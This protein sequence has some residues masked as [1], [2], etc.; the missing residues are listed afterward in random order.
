[1]SDFV[2]NSKDLFF[3]S[4]LISYG[5]DCLLSDAL[6]IISALS[7]NAGMSIIRFHSDLGIF[8]KPSLPVD[9]W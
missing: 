8:S 3:T 2:G 7:N 9:I 1:M 4:R 6:W 5:L